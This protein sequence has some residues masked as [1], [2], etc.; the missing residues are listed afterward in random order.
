[1]ALS[2]VSF[3]RRLHQLGTIYGFFDGDRHDR[4]TIPESRIGG[5][6]ISVL[7]AVLVR[8]MMAVYFAYDVNTP[9]I[10]MDWVWL[11][12]RMSLYPIILD[13]WY[14]WYHRLMHETNLLWRYHRTH[15]LSKHP[16]MLS[17]VFSDAEQA[18][19]DIAAIPAI[20]FL[21]MRFMGL[22]MGFYEWYICLIAAIATEVGGH[23]GL[24]LHIVPPHPLSWVLERLNAELVVEDHDLH[25]RHA[26]RKSYNYGKQTRIWDHVFNTCGERIECLKDNVDYENTVWWPLP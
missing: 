13:F 9:P 5:I 4:D 6:I 2:T 25:H 18:F 19:F 10:S 26:G 21:T 15:H 11:P 12:I 22:S 1:M 17:T 14:Y 16:N 23:S 3:L 20:T 7:S 8:P 24:R